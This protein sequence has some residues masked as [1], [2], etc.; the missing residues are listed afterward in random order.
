MKTSILNIKSVVVLAIV[1]MVALFGNSAY[2]DNYVVNKVGNTQIVYSTDA[3]GLY[4]T[5][6][7]KYV[8]TNPTTSVEIKTALFWSTNTDTWLPDYQ[9]TTETVKGQKTM[10]YARWNNLTQAY[11]NSERMVYQL[12]SNQK[13]VSCE[14]ML[15]SETSKDWITK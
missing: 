1:A 11:N 7:F 10:T 4:L 5:P 8:Y 12:D 14:Y 2:A 13:A 6:K 9:V 15:W 3:T